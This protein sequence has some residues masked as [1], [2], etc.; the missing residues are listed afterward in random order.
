MPTMASSVVLGGSLTNSPEFGFADLCETTD[1]VVLSCKQYF[2]PS[3][4]G[5]F[6]N[7][8]LLVTMHASLSMAP[9]HT[10]C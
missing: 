8:S 5:S 7:R 9:P 10:I 1:Y 6:I 3:S 4:A 2:P